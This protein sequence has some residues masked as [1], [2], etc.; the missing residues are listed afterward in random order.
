MNIK[1]RSVTLEFHQLE[2]KTKSIV[3]IYFSS[4]GTERRGRTLGE[5]LCR[6]QHII[7][8]EHME[9][10]LLAGSGA[11]LCRAPHRALISYRRPPFPQC[12]FEEKKFCG[13]VLDFF[14]CAWPPSAPPSI[15]WW[16]QNKTSPGA[17]SE[18][19]F[20]FFPFSISSFFVIPLLFYFL[21]VHSH[22]QAKIGRS[23][24]G[25]ADS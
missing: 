20:L 17:V 16:H 13:R 2:F 18:T 7:K 19:S 6:L 5:R 24:P 22:G 12:K 4:D 10:A 11:D 9:W 25:V 3:S 1:Q 15:A 21:S 23:P 14:F 8:L